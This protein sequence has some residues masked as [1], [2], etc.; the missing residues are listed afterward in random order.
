MC[1][2]YFVHK[3]GMYAVLHL[4]DNIIAPYTHTQNNILC[5]AFH[6][7]QNGGREP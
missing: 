4:T 6:T 1:F 5:I 3:L 7:K 2:I